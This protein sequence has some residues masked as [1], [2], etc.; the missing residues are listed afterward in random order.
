MIICQGTE[1]SLIPPSKSNR[2]HASI[3]VKQ[4]SDLFMLSSLQN[5]L[6][7]FKSFFPCHRKRKPSVQQ[8]ALLNSLWYS[9][10]LNY[11]SI[12]LDVVSKSF[13]IQCPQ[14]QHFFYFQ[15]EFIYEIY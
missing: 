15:Q 3:H 12:F 2:I 8:L 14:L 4:P 5:Q 1:E 9:L 10:H 6:G 7:D 11:I 13:F